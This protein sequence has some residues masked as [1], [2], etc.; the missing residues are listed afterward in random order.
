[1]N[2]EDRYEKEAREL[3]IRLLHRRLNEHDES[4]VD[5]TWL[6]EAANFLRKRD[7]ERDKLSIPREYID[8]LM[9]DVHDGIEE[10]GSRATPMQETHYEA[11]HSVLERIWNA[12]DI[13]S[14][15]ST[16]ATNA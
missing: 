1:M 6:N 14:D 13:Y 3:Q 4:N 16:E 8:R 2:T 9:H 12:L 5:Q 10:T 15:N 11:S 7:E